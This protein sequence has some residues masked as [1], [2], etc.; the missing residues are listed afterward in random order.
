MQ[1]FDWGLAQIFLAVLETGS[2]TAAAKALGRSQPTVGRQIILLEEQLGVTLFNRTGRALVPTPAAFDLADQARNMR[3][4]AAIISLA[5]TGHSETLEG[6]VLITA[7]EVMATYALPRIIAGLMQ[8][9][10]GLQIELVASNSSENLLLRE[11]DIAIRMHRPEQVDLIARKIGE[12]PM[13]LFAHTSYLDRF[14]RPERIEEFA[15]HIFL[16]YDRSDMMIDGV[17][18]FGIEASKNDFRLRTDNQ[19]SYAE[20]IAAGAGIGATAHLALK[21]RDQIEQVMAEAPIPPMQMWIAAHQ[22]L[23]TSALVRRVFD[24]LAEALKEVCVQ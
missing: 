3:A 17:R 8:E 11:A 12:V 22:E 5:A 14:G 10:R 13:G 4:A 20:A 2:L 23:K 7:S 1:T 21:G 16:G 18:A 24:H 19:V 6:T 9:E 15:D